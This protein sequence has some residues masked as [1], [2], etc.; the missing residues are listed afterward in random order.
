MPYT[1]VHPGFILPFVKWIRNY[2]SIPALIIGSFVP[3]LDIIYRFTETREHIFTYTRYNVFSELVPIGIVL[4][5]YLIW[6]L[7]PLSATGTISFSAKKII[8]DIIRLPFVIICLLLAIYVH[9]FLDHISHLQNVKALSLQVGNSLGYDSNETGN[10]YLLLLYAPQIIVSFIGAILTLI[11]LYLY[12]K[13]IIHSCRFLIKYR[14]ITLLLTAFIMVSFTCMKIIK[15]GIDQSMQ[16]DNILIGITTG[17]MSAFLLVPIAV[18]LFLNFIPE[19]KLLLP[20]LPILG[21]YMFGLVYKEYLAI[22]ILKGIYISFI[23]ILAFIILFQ[24]TFNLKSVWALGTFLILL[25]FH[26][27]TSYFTYLLLFTFLLLVWI[28]YLKGDQSFNLRFIVKVGIGTC[29]LSLAYFASNKGLGKSIFILA[30]ATFCLVSSRLQTLI[31]LYQKGFLFLSIFLT[32]VIIV[33][34]K[35]PLG[36]VAI[37]LSISLLLLS[38][39]YRKITTSQISF[40]FYILGLPLL[41]S[42]YV[43]FQFSRLYGIF[44]LSQLLFIVLIAYGDQI[45]KKEFRGNG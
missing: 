20:L 15:T 23:S 21:F 28:G 1:L 3:D 12:R 35:I 31:P 40:V 4:T 16:I 7:M 43:Y 39:I 45:F 2:I 38:L 8:K 17:W 13:E 6:I 42:V 10:I 32:C 14:S 34:I 11:S 18:Y 30:I 29:L 19:R 37:I 5:Y 25:F 44:S 22:Y 27:F 36:L 9:L 26:P 41:A 33:S 24:D